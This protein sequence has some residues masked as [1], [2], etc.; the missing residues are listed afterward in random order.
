M[1]RAGGDALSIA[2][3][4]ALAV[5]VAGARAAR[6]DDVFQAMAVLRPAAP[7]PAPE[8]EFVS[9]EGR[10]VRLTDLRGKP[11]LLGFFATW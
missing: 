2:L 9:L 8:V 6:A 7:E 11:V 1:K 5:S 4:L 10:P 3:A